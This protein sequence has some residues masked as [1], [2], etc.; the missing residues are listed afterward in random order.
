[1]LAPHLHLLSG[2]GE[3]RVLNVIESEK[4]GAYGSA[5]DR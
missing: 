2:A 3:L 1:L 4:P 5:G